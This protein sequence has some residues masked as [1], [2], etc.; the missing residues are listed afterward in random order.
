MADVDTLI[1]NLGAGDYYTRSTAARL[2]G[3]VGGEKA[4][5][6]LT[7]ALGDEDDWVKE[8]AADSLGKLTYEPA[9][10]SLGKLLQSENYK[11]RSSAAEAL[12]RIGGEGARAL[13]EPLANDE[14]SWVREAVAN[15]L[16]KLAEPRQVRKSETVTHLHEAAD[17]GK[18]TEPGLTV[19]DTPIDPDIRPS[20]PPTTLSDRVPRSAEDIVKLIV[21]GTSIQYKATRSG[22]LLRVPLRDGRRQKVR[23]KFDSVDDDGSPIIQIFTIIGPARPELYDWALKL[24]PGFS[25]GGIG[26]VKIEGKEVL[27]ITDTLLEANVDVQALEKSV[28]TLARKGDELERKL[29]RKDLW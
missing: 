16:H 15:A 20:T 8:Y 25:Y 21:A 28:M 27:A 9:V 7:E 19:D 26:I 6:A 22:F 12:G 14:D 4:A 13:L 10:E 17:I 23:L 1:R 3:E 29:V 2:L 11:V 5:A 24:N 18:E